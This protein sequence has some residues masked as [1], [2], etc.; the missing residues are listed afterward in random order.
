MNADFPIQPLCD[1]LCEL[2]LP[3]PDVELFAYLETGKVMVVIQQHGQRTLEIVEGNTTTRALADRL[4][5]PS[6]P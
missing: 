5:A 3:L 1:R 2:K 4:N 6:E